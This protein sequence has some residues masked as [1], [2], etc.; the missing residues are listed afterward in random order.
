V[1][2]RALRQQ[3]AVSVEGFFGETKRWSS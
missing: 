2:E 3:R 1:Y